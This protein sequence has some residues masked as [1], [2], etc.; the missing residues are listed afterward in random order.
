MKTPHTLR[1]SIP[2]GGMALEAVRELGSSPLTV[3]QVHTQ[4]H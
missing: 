3:L 4:E 1:G 2:G